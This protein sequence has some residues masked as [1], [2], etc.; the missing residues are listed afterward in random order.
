MWI[1]YHVCLSDD[2]RSM[3]E[4][5]IKQEKPK[6]AQHKKRHAQILL[7]IDENHSP[8][9]HEQAAKAFNVKTDTICR[10]RQRLVEEGLDI[11]IN[12]KH[13]RHGGKLKMDGEAEAHLIALTCSA[14]PERRCRWT[15]NLLRDKMIEL[16]Y[17]V[18]PS[19]YATKKATIPNIQYF[20]SPQQSV[21]AYSGNP[22]N[23]QHRTK[24]I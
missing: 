8:L 19:R 17:V 16:K 14:P 23:E 7:A 13:S 11:A 1:K 2:E 4:A 9:T 24:T 21:V 3:L 15:L 22:F 12:S 18:E 5:L 20:L 10:L 6:V